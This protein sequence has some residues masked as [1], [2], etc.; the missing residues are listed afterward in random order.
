MVEAGLGAVGGTMSRN[1]AGAET[2]GSRDT[3]HLDLRDRDSV[4]D[5]WDAVGPDP[6]SFSLM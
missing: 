3:N 5:V 6:H 2:A 4:A 1:T